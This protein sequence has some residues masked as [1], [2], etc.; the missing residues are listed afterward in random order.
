M[1]YYRMTMNLDEEGRIELQKK[2]DTAALIR[3]PLLSQPKRRLRAV[4]SPVSSKEV[5]VDPKERWRAP[6][7]WAPPG[8]SEE[9]SYA[10][11]KQ[12]M[13]FKKEVKK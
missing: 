10:A 13:G 1:A 3:H 4:P 9:R 6:A 5:V 7:G 8:W 2:L 11:A 12:F